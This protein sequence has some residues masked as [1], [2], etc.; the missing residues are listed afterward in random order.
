MRDE[1]VYKGYPGV[2]T[3]VDLLDKPGLRYAYGFYGT[4]EMERRKKKSQD[5]GHK[6]HKAVEEWLKGA[7]YVDIV[8]TFETN[9]AL[10]V[11]NIADWCAVNRLD[12]QL[13]EKSLID[14]E[15][16]FA[17]TADVIGKLNAK[18][19]LYVIDWKTDS[20][21]K[22]S[23]DK[24]ERNFKYGLQLA[25]YALLYSKHLGV[26]INK[27]VIVRSG[28][29]GD[30]AAFPFKSLTRYKKI[31]KGLL[32][33]YNEYKREESLHSKGRKKLPKR[34]AKARKLGR[35][36]EQNSPVGNNGQSEQL[37]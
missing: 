23:K 20:T 35:T 17:G 37:G 1:N 27:G 36:S 15:L 3:V 29:T 26:K 5:I 28:K 14:E 4:V 21:P 11:K 24:A 6:V 22:S 31:F 30:F 7:R 33:I 10:M 8:S 13:M 32:Q 9:Q 18:D 12:V 16:G 25:G 19:E 34:T 2:T